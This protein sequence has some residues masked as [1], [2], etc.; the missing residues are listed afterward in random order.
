VNSANVGSVVNGLT[1]AGAYTGSVGFY[2]T[3]DQ[4]GNAWEW[5]DA[6]IS[7]SFPGVRGG[8]WDF[9][10]NDLRSSARDDSNPVNENLRIGFRVASP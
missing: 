2:G 7:G 1:P 5:N 3:F 4:G 8:S 9:L 6:V 10:E